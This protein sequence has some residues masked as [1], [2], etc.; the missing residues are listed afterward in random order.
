M[1]ASGSCLSR[2]WNVLSTAKVAHSVPGRKAQAGERGPDGRRRSAPSDL[3]RRECAHLLPPCQVGTARPPGPPAWA[4][5][6]AALCPFVAVKRRLCWLLLTWSLQARPRGRTRALCSARPCPRT[7]P[8]PR[9]ARTRAG[10]GRFKWF[11][12]NKGA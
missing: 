11:L 4:P 2:E 10:D 1:P 6:A 3:C 12:A 8:A 7:V 9:A 5:R